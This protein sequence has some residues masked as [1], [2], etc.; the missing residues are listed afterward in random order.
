MWVY[1]IAFLAPLFYAT[2]VVIES[3]LSLSVFKRPIVMLFFV[4]LTNALFTPLILTFGT[5][6]IPEIYSIYIYFII[7]CIDIA[8]LYPY[9]VSF[10]KTDTS[11][12]S[13][14]FSLGKIFVPCLSF[15]LLRDVLS[16]SQYIGFAIIIF[17]SLLLNWQSNV[18]FRINKA[19]YL[20][21]LS[22]FLLACRI[23]LAK[24]AIETDHNVVNVLL[25]PNLISGLIPF[26]FLLFG[27]NMKEIKQKFRVYKKQFRFFVVIEFVTFLAVTTST[28]ALEY[29]S[30][31]ISTAIEATEPLFVLG[32]ISLIRP[33]SS[34]SFKEQENS[35]KK[36]ICFLFIIIG[37]VLT[38]LE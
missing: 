8:Y 25:Y 7:A 4:S 16:V 13:S 22:S 17:T 6:S 35:F 11:V 1:F 34:F 20:M 36:I 27:N 18:K 37:V 2:S 15:I 32:I 19:F 9:Y 5:P 21:F 29:L 12:I 14:L 38:C 26:S 28:I 23:C 10:K 31:T 33:Y 24:Y 30:P 3:F